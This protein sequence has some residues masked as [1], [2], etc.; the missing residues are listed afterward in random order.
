MSS[1]LFPLLPNTKQEIVPTQIPGARVM[2]PELYKCACICVCAL[3]WL[4][5]QGLHVFQFVSYLILICRNT[6]IHTQVLQGYGNE[7]LA[8][9]LEG[10]EWKSERRKQEKVRNREQ[11]ACKQP[12]KQTENWHSH[13]STSVERHRV[14]CLWLCQAVVQ[15]KIR[16]LWIRFD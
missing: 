6:H 13:F 12:Y 10:R 7:S 1:S 3:M 4:R 8:A 9:I 16:L 5:V 15:L 14:F 2:R 11:T